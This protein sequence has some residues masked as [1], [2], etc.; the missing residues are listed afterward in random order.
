MHTKSSVLRKAKNYLWFGTEGVV[1]CSLVYLW[2]YTSISIRPHIPRK[3]FFLLYL[4]FLKLH[5]DPPHTG[6][7]L[8]CCSLYVNFWRLSPFGIWTRDVLNGLIII[9]V[10]CMVN[11]L[12][13]CY[14]IV[15]R[16]L[17]GPSLVLNVLFWISFVVLLT[18]LF[19]SS[20][21]IV[22]VEDWSCLLIWAL[23]SCSN[24]PHIW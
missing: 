7:W 6:G 22:I 9:M 24:N 10:P 15:V 11:E 14:S 16:Q 1:A 3:S 5:F 4:V 2:L 17:Y 21:K 8:F 13:L 19:H 20:K 23:F 12:I 18:L